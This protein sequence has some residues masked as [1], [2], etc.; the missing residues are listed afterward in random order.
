M[1]AIA[2]N[3][4]AQVN[5]ENEVLSYSISRVTIWITYQLVSIFAVILVVSGDLKVRVSPNTIATFSITAQKAGLKGSV[6]L[7]KLQVAS[8]EPRAN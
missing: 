2:L 7:I 8:I 1:E 5:C 3:A 4:K 6:G